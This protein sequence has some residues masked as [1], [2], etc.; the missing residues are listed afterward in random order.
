MNLLLGF[1][2]NQD[3]KQSLR[4]NHVFDGK[5]WLKYSISIWDDVMKTQEEKR[6]SHPASFPTSLVERL[7]DC[8]TVNQKNPV[9]LDPFAGS[10][11]TLVAAK[12]KGLSGIGFEIVKNFIELAHQRLIQTESSLFKDKSEKSN[13]S[14]KVVKTPQMIRLDD[15]QPQVFLINDSALN[16]S[17][18]LPPESISL[19]ITSPPYWKVHRRKRT[20]DHKEERPYSDL[21]EDLGNTEN[22]SDF[23]QKLSTV[24][25]QIYH[26]VRKKAYVIINVMDLRVNSRFI[27]F[28]CDVI[29]FM[30]SIGFTIEDIIIW[31][32]RKDYNNLKPLGYPHKFIANKVHEY[33]LVFSK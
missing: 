23:L 25:Q 14:I 24:F 18:Y 12:K 8:Y 30:T 5:L 21:S 29:S 10:G 4:T 20:A 15:S 1:N 11:T 2:K 16:V 31:D 33:L 27:P 13:H 19:V 32:R 17:K 3:E 6:L 9:V 7:I 22:Y 28:H 26:V